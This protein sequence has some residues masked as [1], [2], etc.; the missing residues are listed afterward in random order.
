MNRL[1]HKKL[2]KN[3]L[4][5]KS[6]KK[7]WIGDKKK[8]NCVLTAFSPTNYS[9]TSTCPNH[10]AKLPLF[11]NRYYSKL[12]VLIL[13]CLILLQIQQ[14]ILISIILI[15][16]DGLHLL[17]L[18]RFDHDSRYLKC[19]TCGM[20]WS[21]TFAS[22]LEMFHILLRLLSYSMSWLYSGRNHTLLRLVSMF[23]ISYLISPSTL[24]VGIYHLQK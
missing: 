19:L 5:T 8:L 4:E 2:P 22:T 24:Q 14:N 1:H 13:S 10:W 18:H 7:S 6:K 17:F 21:P 3:T 11:Y 9:F 16:F 12:S 15:L 23:S 20:M